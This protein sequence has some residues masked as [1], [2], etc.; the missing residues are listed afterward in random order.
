LIARYALEVAGI[1]GGRER[2]FLTAHRGH[3]VR[4]TS[5]RVLDRAFEHEMLEKMRQPRFSGRLVGRAYLVPDH[6]RRD[7]DALVR[8]NHHFQSVGQGEMG[9]LGSSRGTSRRGNDC[10]GSRRKRT[11]V[12]QHEFS[13]LEPPRIAPILAVARKRGR[14]N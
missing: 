6:L 13:L 12:F 1:V 10:E 14:I 9:D 3:H 2:I 11:Y 7:R 4:E 5:S 8:N